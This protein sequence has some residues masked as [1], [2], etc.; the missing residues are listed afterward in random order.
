MEIYESGTK[1]LLK[2]A[3]QEGVIN[4]TTIEYDNVTYNV[5]Y[6]YDGDYKSINLN[7]KE[8]EIVNISDCKKKIGFKR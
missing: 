4:Y 7:E 5:I 3:N 2:L 1:V 8:F 6:F